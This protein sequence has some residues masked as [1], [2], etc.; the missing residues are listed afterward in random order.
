MDMDN[1]RVP[2][3]DQHRAGST[4]TSVSTRS[5]P[6]GLG[7]QNISD[8]SLDLRT[9]PVGT[10]RFVPTPPQAASPQGSSSA[11]SQAST[12]RAIPL[13]SPGAMSYSS[14]L[15]ERDYFP[16]FAPCYNSDVD[17]LRSNRKGEIAVGCPTEGD[18][19]TS[20]WSVLTVTILL[21]AFYSTI[22]SGIFFGIACAQPRWGLRIG[23]PGRISYRTATLLSALL[24]KTIEL[25][26]VSVFVALLGQILR[27][28]RS[29]REPGVVEVKA[30]Q[31]LR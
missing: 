21:L 1:E 30:S 28:E 13:K 16:G 20:P 10:P 11:F 26:F 29:L 8:V 5:T 7:L 3:S 27:E 6:C 25:S 15:A 12:S 22:L 2:G 23:T 18:V 14:A 4:M 19:L 24:S 17:L 31:S 9:V